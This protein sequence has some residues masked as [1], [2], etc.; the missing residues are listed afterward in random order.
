MLITLVPVRLTW[1]NAVTTWKFRTVTKF[2]EVLGEKESR[3]VYIPLTVPRSPLAPHGA[4]FQAEEHSCAAL[5]PVCACARL[6]RPGSPT[7]VAGRSVVW[8]S[9]TWAERAPP[10][11]P[12]MWGRRTSRAACPACRTASAAPP[13][14]VSAARSGAAVGSAVWPLP[15][16]PPSGLLLVGALCLWNFALLLCVNEGMHREALQQ[17]FLHKGPVADR[18]AED[19]VLIYYEYNE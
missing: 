2:C 1:Q 12:W 9:L 18:R 5:R 19:A 13:S 14:W 11:Q 17:L 10:R 4:S 15:A 6:R 7:G 3:K 8:H 16:P